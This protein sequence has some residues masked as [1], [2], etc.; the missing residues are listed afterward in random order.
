MGTQFE[1]TFRALLTFPTVLLVFAGVVMSIL[2][3]G[4]LVAEQSKE[5]VESPKVERLRDGFEVRARFSNSES[6]ILGKWDNNRVFVMCPI[7]LHFM[8]TTRH[9]KEFGN[10]YEEA[11]CIPNPSPRELLL[12]E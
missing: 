7:G 2:L 11:T 8:V 1:Q 6:P 5:K 10:V 3:A 9:G 12:K 4:S